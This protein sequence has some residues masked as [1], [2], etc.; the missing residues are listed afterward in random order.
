MEKNLNRLSQIVTKE[1]IAEWVATA[2]LIVGVALVAFNVYPLGIWFSLAGNLGWL[3]V[4]WMWR[5]YSLLTIQVI[6]ATIYIVGLI[7]YYGT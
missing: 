6:V 7:N 5:K 1:W 2:I 4:G 3:V